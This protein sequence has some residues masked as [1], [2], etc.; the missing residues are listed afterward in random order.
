MAKS[1][2]SGRS[3]SMVAQT[4]TGGAP[5]TGRGVGR[6]SGGSSITVELDAEEVLR[7]IGTKL[8]RLGNLKG[9]FDFV[10][11]DFIK[12]EKQ[13]FAKNGAVAGFVKWSPLSP[14]THRIKNKNKNRILVDRGDLRRSF[15]DK[16]DKFFFYKRGKSFMEIG[17]KDELAAIH[18]HGNEKMNLPKRPMLR[19]TDQRKKKWRSALLRHL[20]AKKSFGFERRK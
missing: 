1:S 16:N 14:Q 7:S 4:R 11:D 13:V 6:S 15:T 3:F 12:A 8:G 10:R 5:S 2:L 18:Y 17:S 20:V 9:Y 19:I